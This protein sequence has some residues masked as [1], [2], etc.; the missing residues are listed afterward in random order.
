MLWRVD[1]ASGDK[2]PFPETDQ[3]R[4]CMFGRYL[5]ERGS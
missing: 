2:R 5:P 4:Q 3:Q 1:A